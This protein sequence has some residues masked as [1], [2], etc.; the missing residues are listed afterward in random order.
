MSTNLNNDQIVGYANRGEA[1]QTKNGNFWTVPGF[2]GNCGFLPSDLYYG[3][4]AINS[5]GVGHRIEQTI[6]S[7]STPIAIKID[8]VWIIPDVTYSATTS[9]KHATHLYRLR[10]RIEYIPRDASVEEIERV[11]AGKQRYVRSHK[12]GVPGRYI[13]GPNYVDGE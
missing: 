2:T 6:Y 5:Q 4:R 8:G 12:S 13:P 10:D 7:Y 9:S 1:G 3:F 11:I